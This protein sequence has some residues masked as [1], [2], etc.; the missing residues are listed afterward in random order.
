MDHYFKAHLQFWF[1]QRLMFKEVFLKH[2][3]AKCL[4]N[5][6]NCF[7]HNIESFI[8]LKILV[9]E[10]TNSW[11]I[12]F[13]LPNLQQLI[14]K[15]FFFLLFLFI[16]PLMYLSYVMIIWLVFLTLTCHIRTT[17][18]QCTAQTWILPMTGW[19]KN[20]DT[21]KLLSNQT[22]LL[23][24]VYT[25]QL[26]TG[27]KM[28]DKYSTLIKNTVIGTMRHWSQTNWLQYL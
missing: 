22:T 23:C 28:A 10:N 3:M 24:P 2:W 9:P 5:L 15:I 11:R 16:I 17:F 19:V 4:I 13:C 26:S 20:K 21:F 27:L 25:F 6:S 1:I 12:T 8:L 7:K 14:F 18:M